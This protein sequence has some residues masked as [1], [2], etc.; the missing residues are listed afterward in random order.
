MLGTTKV[1]YTP[2]GGGEATQY[3]DGTVLF[4][5]TKQ[6][7]VIATVVGV[8]LKLITGEITPNYP[9]SGALKNLYIGEGSKDT[10]ITTYKSLEEAQ[11]ACAPDKDCIGVTQEVG[12]VEYSTR[13]GSLSPSPTKEISWAKTNGDVYTIFDKTYIGEGSK[14]T[15]I[16]T[17]KSLEEAQKKCAPDK[18]CIGVTQE[19]GGTPVEYSTRKGSLSPSP[20]KEISW[21]KTF[22]V[23]WSIIVNERD[24]TI[25]K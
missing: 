11:K 7:D 2:S 13:K 8:P 10:R 3:V 18:D 19:V 1:T 21:I 4:C 23:P 16:T 14:D 17:Y 24:W 6:I 25:S 9:F 20:T 5:N 15:R 22:S 12:G